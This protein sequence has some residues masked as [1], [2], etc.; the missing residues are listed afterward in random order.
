MTKLKSSFAVVLPLLLGASSLQSQSAEVANQILEYEKAAVAR[1]KTDNTAGGQS[2]GYECRICLNLQR[3][4]RNMM[5]HLLSAHQFG[6]A[7]LVQNLDALIAPYHECQAS[8]TYLCK[9]CRKILRGFSFVKLRAH[10]LLVHIYK[11][12]QDETF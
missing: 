8:N 6:N 12:V 9:L 1:V 2:L 7:E 3:G 11:E 5:C 10:F 4:R